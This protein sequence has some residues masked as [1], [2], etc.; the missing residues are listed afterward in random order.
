MNGQETQKEM[1]DLPLATL[2][3]A[4]LQ[5]ALFLGHDQSMENKP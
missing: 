1:N 2:A 5:P 3:H 4:T